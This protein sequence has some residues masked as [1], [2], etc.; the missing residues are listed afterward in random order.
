MEDKQSTL[1]PRRDGGHAG[2][3]PR[4]RAT[5]LRF[6]SVA[7]VLADVTRAEGLTSP[8]FR[9]PPGLVGVSRSIRRRRQGP[10]TVAVALRGRPWAA[11]LAD[12]VEGVVAANRLRGVAA[13]RCR[14]RLWG[15]LGEADEADQPDETRGGAGQ[16]GDHEREDERDEPKATNEEKAQGFA[17]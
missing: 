17:A 6:G 4:R 9:S 12:M 11:V 14:A 7:A 8:A 13:D 5:S 16:V 1:M 15:A 2:P 10:A 3:A